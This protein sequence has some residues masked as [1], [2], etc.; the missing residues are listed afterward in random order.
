VTGTGIDPGEGAKHEQASL[1]DVGGAGACAAGF[2]LGQGALLDMAANK[3][4]GKFDC[5]MIP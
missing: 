4:I 3:V 5:G 2:A 1:S